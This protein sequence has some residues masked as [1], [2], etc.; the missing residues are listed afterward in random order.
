MQTKHVSL[1]DVVSVSL[2]KFCDKF[3]EKDSKWCEF[4]MISKKTKKILRIVPCD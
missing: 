3:T 2:S 4:A 1:L